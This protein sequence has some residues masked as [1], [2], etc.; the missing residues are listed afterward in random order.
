MIIPPFKA[1]PFPRRYLWVVAL[2]LSV[3]QLLQAY[4]DYRLSGFDFAFSWYVVS[5]KHLSIYISWVLLATPVYTIAVAFYDWNKKRSLSRFAQLLLGGI[6][7]LLLHVALSTFINDLLNYPN[8][9]YIRT[10]FQPNRKPVFVARAF[11]G[12]LQYIA[13]TSFFVAFIY[14]QNYLNQQKALNRAKLDALMMQLRPHFLFNTLNSIASLIDIDAKSAQKMVLQLSKLMRQVLN[15]EGR[16]LVTLA[17]EIQFLRHYMDIESIR[18][19]DRLL[20]QFDIAE[21]TLQA[22]I[23]SLLLQPIV[24]NAVKHGVNKRIEDARLDICSRLLQQNN[25]TWLELQVKDNG[26][27]FDQNGQDPKNGV[28]LENVK[29]RLQQHYL[30]HFVFRMKSQIGQ[31][32][33]VNIQIP[34]ETDKAYDETD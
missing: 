32:C 28:G 20:V 14:Y 10:W 21:Q 30:S 33:Q 4:T 8:L 29:N 1:L 5:S 18:F 27:G 34:F 7:F 6:I 11:T 26:P 16:D 12:T 31:G 19:K 15:K 24:E 2:L 23:P 3:F 22:K 25:S 9:G 13:F 17:E